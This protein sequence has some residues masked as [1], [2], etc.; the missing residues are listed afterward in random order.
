MNI[1]LT[2]AGGFVGGRLAE[3]LNNMDD[4]SVVLLTSRMKNG[5]RCVEHKGYKFSTL[6]LLMD[7]IDHF[8]AV[9]HAGAYA[10]KV[11]GSEDVAMN[12][13]SL[14][15]TQYL[16]TL[17]GIVAATNNNIRY[18]RIG[19]KPTQRKDMRISAEKR[20]T[21]LGEE[22]YTLMQGI[23]KTYIWTKHQQEENPDK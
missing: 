19:P 20:L 10:P 6:D 13:A 15:N 9:I 23:Q 18:R 16:L 2:G 1:L 17:K 7:D 11:A 4:V 12:F 21:L 8:D 3:I 14:R 22:E 5:Y